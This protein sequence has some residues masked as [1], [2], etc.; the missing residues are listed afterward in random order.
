MVAS[1]VYTGN[2]NNETKT[3]IFDGK[4]GKTAS[5]LNNVEKTCNIEELKEKKVCKK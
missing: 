3:Y 1:A 4:T 5:Y 2:P